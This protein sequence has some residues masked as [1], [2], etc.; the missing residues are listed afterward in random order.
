MLHKMKLKKEP[1]EMIKSGKKI[2]EL[3]LYDEKRKKLKIGD[4]VEFEKYRYTTLRLQYLIEA[5]FIGFIR[6]FL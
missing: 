1:F 5:F 2:Y 3:R 6:F 4:T